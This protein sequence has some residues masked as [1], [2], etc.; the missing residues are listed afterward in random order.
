MRKI[1]VLTLIWLQVSMALIISDAH[2][3]EINSKG[4]ASF[5]YVLPSSNKLPN[6]DSSENKTLKGKIITIDP[7]HGGTDVGA[8]GIGN[9][10]EKDV[11][12]RIS[13]E[14]HYMLENDG[15]KVVMTRE[16]D[17]DVAGI[18]ATASQE[19]GKR[20]A[21]AQEANANVFVS[22]HIDSFTN[23]TVSGTTSFYFSK[24]KDDFELANSMQQNLVEVLKLQ[25][26]GVRSENFYVLKYAPM[27]AVL[28]EIAFI[29]NPLEAKLLADPTFAHKAALGLYRGLKQYFSQAESF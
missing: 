9:L 3:Q 6:T 23:P 19:L 14:L 5:D 26:R 2:A 27:P 25:N 11:T 17:I 15:A 22:I 7:G 18:G 10:Q 8:I 21:I 24:A 29:S 16:Q 12:L 4:L 20:L 1:V 13:H 28:T